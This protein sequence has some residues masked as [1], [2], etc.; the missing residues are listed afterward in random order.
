MIRTGRVIRVHGDKLYVC[1]ERHEAC[2][3]CG[4]CGG[5]KKDAVIAVCGSASPGDEVDV[6]MPDAQVV[7]ASFLSYLVPLAGFLAGLFTLNALF[8]RSD[9]AGVL[10]GLV[11]MGLCWGALIVLDSRL[12]RRAPWQPRVAAVRRPAPP[13]PAGA[14]ALP[15]EGGPAGLR[16]PGAGESAQM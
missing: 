1:I 11:G 13:A 15:P 7:K 10:G 12:S 8:P 14:E 2:Q 9:L 4:A 6:E 3:G 5:R 16:E